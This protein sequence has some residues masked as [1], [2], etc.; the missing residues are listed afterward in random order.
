MSFS[1]SPFKNSVQPFCFR[2]NEEFLVSF[3]LCVFERNGNKFGI[4][5]F[6]YLC[7]EH[8]FDGFES[9]LWHSLLLCCSQA[10]FDRCFLLSLPSLFPPLLT[11][12]TDE[13]AVL[14]WNLRSFFC[15]S[16]QMFLLKKTVH[17][18][19]VFRL[20]AYPVEISA[21]LMFT[22]NLHTS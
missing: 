6:M 14:A 13:Q 3:M 20:M 12:K 4:L 19:C 8:D 10:T 9:R 17:I 1:I 22:F 11:F 7:P 21:Y 18:I 5:W 15:I 2:Q 16:V